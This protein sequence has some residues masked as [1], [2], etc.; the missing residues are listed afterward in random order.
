MNVL[1]IMFVVVNIWLMLAYAYRLK[2]NH[3]F[4]YDDTDEYD[5]YDEYDDTG[6]DT[7]DAD[8]ARIDRINECIE[9]IE[10]QTG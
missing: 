2:S 9:T 10:E 1:Q 6:P 7:I 4:L 5:E 8:R 3:Y